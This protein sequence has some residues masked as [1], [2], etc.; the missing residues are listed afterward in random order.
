[1]EVPKC[2]LSVLIA[3]TTLHC[4][5]GEVIVTTK[6][7]KIRG[8]SSNKTKAFLGVP[9]A[10]PPVGK[11]RYEIGWITPFSVR[12]YTYLLWCYQSHMKPI[13]IIRLL[14]TWIWYFL[15]HT[16]ILRCSAFL[17]IP[18]LGSNQKQDFHPSTEHG[19]TCTKIP[20][21]NKP[22]IT[23]KCTHILFKMICF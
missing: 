2:L 20:V 1:M 9:Y 23:N 5:F 16:I 15:R 17:L 3:L 18:A 13:K 14:A 7:G 11:L 22:V 12:F 21:T 10:A 8:I 19:T 4:A 6:Y